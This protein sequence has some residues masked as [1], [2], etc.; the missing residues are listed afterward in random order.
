MTT[1][2]SLKKKRDRVR[3]LTDE[4]NFHNHRY[5]ALDDP[6]IS[7]SEYDAL[8][9]ELQAIESEYPAL[10]LPNSP[11]QRV[12][13]QPLSAFET[14]KHHQAMFSLDNAFSYEELSAFNDRILQRLKISDEIRYV[15]EPKFDGVAINLYYENGVLMSAATRGDGTVGENVTENVR[16]ILA[17]PLKLKGSDYPDKCEIRGE[18]VMPKSGFEALNNQAR[19]N[20][21]KVFANPRNAAAGSLRQLDSRITAKRPLRFYAYGLVSLTESTKYQTHTEMMQQLAS[22]GFPVSKEIKTVSGITACESYYKAILKKRNL[23]AFE[24]DGVVYKADSLVIQKSLGYVA[25]APRWAIAYKFPAEEKTTRVEKI[26]FQVGRTGAI[27]PVARL[28]PVHVAGVTVSNATLHNFDELYRKDVRVG[29]TVIIRRAGDVIPEVVKVIID[30]RPTQTTK[31]PMPTQCPICNSKLLKADGE[32]VLRCTGGLYCNAQRQEAIK[33][34]ASRRAMDIDGLGDKLVDLLVQH[35]LV[36][37]IPDIYHLSLN[38]LAALPRMGV[39]SAENLLDAIETSKKTTFARFLY[40]LGIREVGLATANVL[41]TAFGD[42]SRLM[43]ANIDDLQALSDIGPIVS[44]HIVAF[45][46]E[47][48]NTTMIQALLD[49]GIHWEKVKA[50][51]KSEQPLDGQT[52]VITG[53][54]QNLSRDDAKEKLQRLGAKV[55]GTV[56][57]KTSFLVVGDAPGSKYDKAQSLGIKCLDE[58]AFLSLI[59]PTED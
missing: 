5:Y 21:E 22:W 6:I 19:A 56:S 30:K 52:I 57:K 12:G 32:A 43:Q 40:A 35:N 33:H 16:T 4:L 38:H 29:D 3:T 59:Q 1:T 31:T 13:T 42:L 48:H 14:S 9:R 8:F 51:P 46:K 54:L 15:C 45:F 36:T 20:D 49:A 18:I 34:F 26:E 37:H 28:T 23:L 27:T 41:A 58:T 50:T 24:I 7:D 53:T 2:D 10:Q 25:R 47:P 11:T 55:T 39:K 44:A 17:I